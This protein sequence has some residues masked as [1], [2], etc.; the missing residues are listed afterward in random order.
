MIESTALLLDNSRVNMSTYS[1]NIISAEGQNITS[2]NNQ[3]DSEG[4]SEG[5]SSEN[6]EDETRTWEARTPMWIIML[7][8]IFTDWPWEIATYISGDSESNANG[9]QSCLSCLQW[10]C[11]F[12]RFAFVI[13]GLIAQTLSCFRRDRLDQS[14]IQENN[15]TREVK[16][17]E[18]SQV[19]SYFIVPDIMIFLIV[20]VLLIK[21]FT[22]KCSMELAHI[23]IINLVNEIKLTKQPE[24]YM[25]RLFL[26]LAIVYMF[27]SQGVSIGSMFAFNIVDDDT[28]IDSELKHISGSQ[29]TVLIILSF[30]GFIAYDLIYAQIIMRYV[31]QCEMN[32]YFLEKIKDKVGLLRENDDINYYANQDEALNDVEKAYDFFKQ[33]NRNGTAVGII[34]LITTLQAINSIISLLNKGNTYWQETALLA[35]SAQWVFLTMS[36]LYQ[37][38]KVNKASKTLHEIG[39]AMYRRPVLFE[40]NEEIQN[41]LVYKHPYQITLKAK[42]FGIS[43]NP[44]FPYVIFILILFTLIVGVGFK[45]YEHVL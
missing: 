24:K 13:L 15:A 40:G 41:R 38:A 18:T 19:F 3:G 36:T 11:V 1:L 45:W 6:S 7:T 22:G 2:N 29:K 28:I 20:L 21:K 34:I 4:E 42:L 35:R 5:S 8:G 12:I 37:A 9:P 33:L 32:I 25:T 10:S 27:F 31:F 30:F 39:L 43:I 23:D 44:W 16:C 26:A 14:I 17:N